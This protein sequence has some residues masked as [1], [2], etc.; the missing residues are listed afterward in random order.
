MN[1]SARIHVL[2]DEPANV[3]LLSRLLREAGFAE[4]VCST[5]SRASL[6]GL[7]EDPP[8]L[9]LLDLHMPYVDGY[10]VL[11]RLT[12]Q[13]HPDEFLPVLVVTADVTDEARRR[14]LAAGA[15]DFLTKPFDQIEVRLRVGNLLRTRGLHVRLRE[16][17]DA[18]EQ[19]L[20]T[21]RE[22]QA[23]RAA[24]HDAAV[25][26]IDEV[27]TSDALRVVYQPIV[28]L[29]TGR[30]A[31]VEALSRFELEPRRTPDVW[32]AEA[33]AVGLGVDLE[34]AAVLAACRGFRDGPP[35]V[36]LSVNVSPATVLAV[37]PDALLGDVEPA[38]L[39]LELTEHAAVEDYAAL[40]A[41]LA[42]LRRR[43]VRVAVDDAGSGFAS[44]RH[45]LQLAPHV[46]KLDVGLTRDVDLD[47]VKRSLCTAFASFA[48]EIGAQLVGEGIERAQERDVLNRLGVR[49]GQGYLLAR[50][51]DLASL[52]AGCTPAEL[53]LPAPRPT[54]DGLAARVD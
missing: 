53:S 15:T 44:L 54:Q 40:N 34:L 7:L 27:L 6:V 52:P 49:Y 42:A 29:G 32:F 30:V 24:E 35:G 5:D 41:A 47:P 26:R 20:T 2:D 37:H 33:G 18:L 11:E 16:R 17:R 8:D 22:E 31:G 3:V 21:Q 48:A 50:P 14:A 45:V 51:G 12:A 23:R 19:E 1:A 46:I 43:G 25:R 38:R 28:E 4:V 13:L 9:L 39:V 10:Q 36:Y